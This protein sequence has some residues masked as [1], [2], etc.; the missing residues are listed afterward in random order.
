MQKTNWKQLMFPGQDTQ[1]N[2]H[3]RCCGGVFFHHRTTPDYDLTRQWDQVIAVC[4]D[5]WGH[6]LG[7]SKENF[8]L[9]MLITS[10]ISFKKLLLVHWASIIWLPN[11]GEGLIKCQQSC[12]VFFPT[13]NSQGENGSPSLFPTWHPV[14]QAH[15]PS[16]QVLSGTNNS[17]QT[18]STWSET[19]KTLKASMTLQHSAKK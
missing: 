12:K 18:A 7:G 4:L 3:T 6:Y 8:P 2:Q 5:M 16:L 17:V 1:L 15:T 10:Q 13:S 11:A 9:V 14:S 19:I